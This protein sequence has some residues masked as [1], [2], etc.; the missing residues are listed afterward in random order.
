VAADRLESARRIVSLVLYGS[1]QTDAMTL[2]IPKQAKMTGLRVRGENVQIAK[3]WSGD[4]LINCDGRD[5]RDLAVTLTLG[6]HETV[7]LPFAERHYG[8]PTFGAPLAAARPATAIPSQSGDGAI[9]AN[10]VNLP[11]RK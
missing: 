9:L 7:T 5:C 4:T 2:R 3:D 11:S 6:S 8:L 10:T 1:A